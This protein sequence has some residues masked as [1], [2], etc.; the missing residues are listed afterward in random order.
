MVHDNCR[1]IAVTLKIPPGRGF[2]RYAL[3]TTLTLNSSKV[4]K[5]S[6]IF[7]IHRRAYVTFPPSRLRGVF[8]FISS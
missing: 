4:C 6:M 1:N 2:E 5:G 7:F 8:N 3:L